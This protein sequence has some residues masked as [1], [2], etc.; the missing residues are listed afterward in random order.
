MNSPTITVRL[1]DYLMLHKT[2]Q[3][4]LDRAGSSTPEDVQAMRGLVRGLASLV[5]RMDVKEPIAP[6]TG[7][8][9]V[10]L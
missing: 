4:M 6:A 2:V 7:S 5:M 9:Q 1:D 10:R 8:E 3:C